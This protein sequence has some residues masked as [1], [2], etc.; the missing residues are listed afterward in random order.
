MKNQDTF[1]SIIES[2]KYY[3]TKQ[4]GDW[5]ECLILACKREKVTTQLRAGKLS[6]SFR[7]GNGEIRP[8]VGTLSSDLFSYESKG[9]ARN[10]NPDVIA[11]YDINSE[12]W[13]AFRIERLLEVA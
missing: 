7:K 12:G 5:K 4:M 2:A 11:Y 3:F 10:Y 9:E 1:N 6:F 8:A 13:R